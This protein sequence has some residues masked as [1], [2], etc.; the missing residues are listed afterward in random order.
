MKR[1]RKIAAAYII[2]M[3]AGLMGMFIHVSRLKMGWQSIGGYSDAELEIYKKIWGNMGAGIDTYRHQLIVCMAVFW[4]VLFIGGLLFIW[5]VY[6]KEIK[7]VEE[8]QLFARE[9]AK[10]N[11]DVPLPIRKGD[12]YGGFTESFDLMREELKEAKKRELEADRTKREFAAELSH[13]LKTPV[14]TIRATCDV[15]DITYRKYLE[16]I[17]DSD[18]NRIDMTKDDAENTL[19]KINIISDRINTISELVDDVFHANLD[20]LKEVQVI[21]EET[22]SKWIEECF[23]KMK[24]YGNIIIDG[25]IPQCLVYLDKLRM[26][27]VIDN[28]VSNSYKYAG[29]D[30]HVSFE[31]VKAVPS[32]FIKV[33]IRDFGPGVSNEE[34]PL[35][36]EKYYRG[37][38]EKNKPGYG[39]GMYLVNRYMELQHGGLQYHNDGGFVVELFVAKV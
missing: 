11:L 36:V 1:L 17:Y 4:A 30:I 5:F 22:E 26:E 13:D 29:T 39:L 3:I 15:L 10:G 21:P 19:E 9:I 23:L 25:H 35:I 12:H 2:L 6:K 14:A 16:K 20:D 38:R 18:E 8:M 34:L 33:T 28:V 32:R 31:E 7:P 27:Q 24:D 37:K